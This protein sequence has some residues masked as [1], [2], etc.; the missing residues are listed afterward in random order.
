MR[1][2][3]YNVQ[4]SICAKRLASNGTPE[5]RN[6]LWKQF[7]NF[8]FSYI[9]WCLSRICFA[10]RFWTNL[11]K[12]KIWAVDKH[13]SQ[14][15]RTDEWISP[16]NIVRSQIR[17]IASHC[18]VAMEADFHLKWRCEEFPGM[19]FPYWSTF[20]HDSSPESFHTIADQSNTTA[21]VWQKHTNKNTQECSQQ[22]NHKP[23]L[24]PSIKHPH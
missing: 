21:Q 4:R 9:N 6:P 23:T 22:L 3:R 11:W 19:S 10:S 8:W 17:L 24:I 1:L 15:L 18:W 7:Y 20:A 12:N 16:I 5:T 13:T 2:G 14:I